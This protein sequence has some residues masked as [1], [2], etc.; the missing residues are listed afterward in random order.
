MAKHRLVALGD[1]LTQGFQS[2][3]VYNTDRSYPKLIAECLGLSDQEFRVPSFR[4]AS[5]VDYMGPALNLEYMARAAGEGD[6]TE[7]SLLEQMEMGMKALKTAVEIRI[8]WDSRARIDELG[9]ERLPDDGEIVHNL[10][11]AGFDVRDLMARTADTDIA[12]LHQ[13]AEFTD[14][15]LVP[16][17]ARGLISLPVL[18]TAR[19][20]GKSLTPVEAA[21]ALGAE[22]GIETLIVFIGAN[23]ALGSILSMVPVESGPG[24]DDPAIKSRYNLWRPEHFNV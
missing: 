23:N 24:Y 17:N 8:H 4:P 11:V 21:Q 6:C 19:R 7:K 2:F 18:K 12:S 14:L 13:W 16:T 22:G 9:I 20:G 1:S 10:S 15:G 3:A 5:G